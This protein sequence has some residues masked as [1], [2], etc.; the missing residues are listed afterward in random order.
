MASSSNRETS[1]KKVDEKTVNVENLNKPKQATVDE[2]KKATHSEIPKLEHAPELSRTAVYEQEVE[3]DQLA[4]STSDENILIFDST[5]FLLFDDKLKQI[6]DLEW[7]EFDSSGIL[8]IDDL[9][10][11]SCQKSYLVLTRSYIYELNIDSFEIKLIKEF[12]KKDKSGE[13]KSEFSSIT[14]HDDHIFIAYTNASAVSK[15]TWK[16]TLQLV[17]RWTKAKVVEETDQSILSI[18]TDGTHV[19]L[20]IKGD[21]TRLEVF[22]FNLATRIVHHL[23]LSKTAIMLTSLA[24]NQWLVTDS[25]Q[26]ELSLI[27][28]DNKIQKTQNKDS[29]PLNAGRLGNDYLVVKC[30]KPNKLQIFKLD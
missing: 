23:E 13:D 1:P 16:P 3:T 22:D 20:L 18:R 5:K 25:E 28:E 30:Q 14:A 27:N 8:T 11:L 21:T 10:Y 19:G 4:L 17:N 6:K 2:S 9:A 12:S 15:W 24:N 7:K 29:S 26:H